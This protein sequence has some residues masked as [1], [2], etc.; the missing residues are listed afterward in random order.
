MN[1]LALHEFHRGLGARFLDVA[2]M[3][4]VSDYGDWRAEHAAL[5][6]SAGVLDLGFRGRLCVLGADRQRFLN[7]QV[8][9]NVKEL[10]PGQGCY[11]AL[12][13]AKGKMVCDLNLYCLAD[14][15]LLDF[16]PGLS[17]AVAQRLDQFIIAD[18]VRLADAAPHYGLLSVQGPKAAELVRS[19]GPGWPPPDTAQHIATVD[20]AAPG[21]VYCAN[22]PRCGSAGFDLFVPVAALAAVA[23]KLVAAA[24]T[25]GGGPCG[26]QALETARIE[27]AL[28]R[29]GADMDESNLPPEAGLEGRAISYSKG[30]YIGQEVISRIRAHGQVAKSLRGLLLPDAASSLPQRGDKL[31]HEG[32]EVGYVTSAVASPALGANIALGY[33]RREIGGAGVALE[34]R[35]GTGVFPAHL[36]PTPFAVET[37]HGVP[38]PT[39][40]S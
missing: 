2:G 29:F 33:V 11:A 6:G 31:F 24:R 4:A 5:R 36:V 14:E 40:R 17:G 13:T 19:M 10:R 37:L 1:A 9:N 25:L 38:A 26:W 35:T 34:C 3:E 12:I 27:A 22:A 16:E 7:G 30:C 23:E 39:V 8:T 18:D 15:F 28:P 21:A 20:A 32:K